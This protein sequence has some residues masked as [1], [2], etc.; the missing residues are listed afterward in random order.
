MRAR[1]I[2]AYLMNLKSAVREKGVPSGLRAPKSRRSRRQVP[3][4]FLLADQLNWYAPLPRFCNDDDP[5][6]YSSMASVPPITDSQDKL[7]E[8]TCTAAATRSMTG[9][10]PRS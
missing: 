9:L 5:A 7:T 3:A 8:V 4:K 10:P 2:S 1:E 6:A